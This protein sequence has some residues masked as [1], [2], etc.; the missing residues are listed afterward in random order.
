MGEGLEVGNRCV[1][2]LGSHGG[3]SVGWSLEG[4]GRCGSKEGEAHVEAGL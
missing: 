4:M 2:H 1:V 3:V